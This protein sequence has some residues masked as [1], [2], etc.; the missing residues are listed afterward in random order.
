MNTVEIYT[1]SENRQITVTVQASFFLMSWLSREEYV[2][3]VSVSGDYPLA[4]LK[5]VQAW[6]QEG[7]PE[8]TKPEVLKTASARWARIS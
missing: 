7:Q 6:E 5:E 4:I 2:K 1:T 8:E 3:T